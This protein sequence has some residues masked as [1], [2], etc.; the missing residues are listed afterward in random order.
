MASQNETVVIL[1]SP[2]IRFLRALAQAARRWRQIR[3]DPVLYA[4]WR[5]SVDARR[6]S[7]SNQ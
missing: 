2:R 1:E 3:D 4:R 6:R 5:E 7:L